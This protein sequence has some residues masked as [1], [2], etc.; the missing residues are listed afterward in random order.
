MIKFGSR[1][2][3][4]LPL[5]LVQEVHV[6]AGDRVKGGSIILLRLGLKQEGKAAGG[7]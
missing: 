7:V 3:V 6:K 4:L 2:E 1:T 5:D